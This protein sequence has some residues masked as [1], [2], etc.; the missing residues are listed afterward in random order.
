MNHKIVIVSKLNVALLTTS[1]LQFLLS[2]TSFY[3]SICIFLLMAINKLNLHR[4]GSSSLYRKILQIFQ[5][6]LMLW[7]F[8]I[9]GHGGTSILLTLV[10]KEYLN[11]G[12]FEKRYQIQKT[13]LRYNLH[14]GFPVLVKI[15]YKTVQMEQHI[16]M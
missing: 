6:G 15:F 1:I 4:K 3:I 16:S 2:H 7:I 8:G 13:Q 12:W 14:F 10:L 5:F 9:V 11:E